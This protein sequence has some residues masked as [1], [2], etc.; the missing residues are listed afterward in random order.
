ML[1]LPCCGRCAALIM[2]VSALYSQVV[3]FHVGVGSCAC[4]NKNL[5]TRVVLLCGPTCIILS[6]PTLQILKVGILKCLAQTIMK[7]RSRRCHRCCVCYCCSFTASAVLCCCCV[8]TLIIW[9]CV[10]FR[11]RIFT[12]VVPVA[13]AVAHEIYVRKTRVMEK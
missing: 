12:T 2:Y 6:Y 10:V 7:G 11:L 5:H 8:V 3:Q 9:V 1:L 13:P 4:I